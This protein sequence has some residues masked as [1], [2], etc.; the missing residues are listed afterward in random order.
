MKVTSIELHPANSAFVAQLSFRDASR[1][2]PYNVRDVGG[3]DAADLIARYYGASGNSA[4]SFYALAMMKRDLVFRIQLNPAFSLGKSYSDLRDDLYRVISSSRTGLVEIQFKNG[5][6]VV[7]SVSGIVSKFENTLFDKSPEVQITISARNAFL[8]DPVATAVPVAGLSL[9]NTNLIDAISTAPHGFSFTM[10]V[11]VATPSLVITDPTAVGA[12]SFTVTPA[13]GFVVGDVIHF[14]SEIDA[15]TLYLV[16]GGVTIYLA[17]VIAPGSMWPIMFP[18]DNHFA[19][20]N[21]ANFAWTS[22]SYFHTY[23]GV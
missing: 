22:I 9:A 8:K 23:W 15:K 10:T 6:V 11:G 18:F 4:A 5:A 12:W 17:D 3:L 21:P 16:R 1:Q 13:G 20:A 2:N 7:A 14:S 19:I